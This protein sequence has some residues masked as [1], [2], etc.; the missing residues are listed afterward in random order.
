[1]FKTT[2]LD[3]VANEYVDKNVGASI[4]GTRL[5]ADD[6][7]ILQDELVAIVEE[8]GITLD[9]TGTN[10]NQLRLGKIRIKK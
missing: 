5:E 1:M 2:A 10:R 3:H 4:P 8:L 9:A 6:R 7:N